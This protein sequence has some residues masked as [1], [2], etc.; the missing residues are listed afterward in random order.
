M[1]IGLITS[2]HI[3]H[4]FLA[5]ILVREHELALVLAEEKRRNPADVSGTPDEQ[6]L[7][8]EYFQDRAAAEASLLREGQNWD[9]QIGEVAPVPPGEINEPQWPARMREAGVELIAVFGTSILRE[10]WLET[11]PGR[12]VNMHLGLSPYYRGAATNFWPLY[13]EEP[14]YVGATIHLINAGVDTGP[15]LQHARPRIA[16]ADT[17]HTIGNR[18]I[19]AGAVA[20]CGSLREY[21]L[22]WIVPVQQ[23]EVPS[24]RY[25]RNRDFTPAVLRNFI[26]R[27][28]NGLLPRVLHGYDH[29][30]KTVR[31]IRELRYE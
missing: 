4:R 23:W 12:L 8:Q 15:I 28:Q 2:N 6:A 24:S 31:L 17:P 1:R 27:W 16:A 13:Y 5:N 18:A 21:A 30:C 11:F 3:R 22:D 19:R 26:D 14:E 29:R 9:P 10:P 20:M 7:V 25:C